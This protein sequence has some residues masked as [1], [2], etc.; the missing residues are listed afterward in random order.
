MD[1]IFLKDADGMP[2]FGCTSCYKC[3]SIFGKS[4]CKIKNRGSKKLGFMQFGE[5]YKRLIRNVKKWSG[6]YYAEDIDEAHFK[7]IMT[8]YYP[9]GGHQEQEVGIVE[10][11]CVD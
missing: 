4:L 1:K 8:Y 6:D 9:R 11:S 3:S 7:V 10:V 2:Q 5:F